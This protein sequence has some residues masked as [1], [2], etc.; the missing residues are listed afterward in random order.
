LTLATLAIM[1]ST[2]LTMPIFLAVAI[3]SMKAVSASS[4]LP[5]ATLASPKPSIE[6][7]V[8]RTKATSWQRAT[9]SV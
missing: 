2:S 9:S 6:T 8:P 1:L 5:A 3:A 4:S 7:I